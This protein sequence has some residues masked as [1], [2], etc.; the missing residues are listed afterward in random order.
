MPAVGCCC[1]P[2]QCTVCMC[3]SRSNGKMITGPSQEQER[4]RAVAGMEHSA[5][6]QNEVC[7][8]ATGCNQLAVCSTQPQQQQ[9]DELQQARCAGAWRLSH[10]MAEGAG[11]TSGVAGGVAEDVG[12]DRVP[13]LASRSPTCQAFAAAPKAAVA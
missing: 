9:E 6:Q 4:V 7:P 3:S 13:Y 1:L 5:A 11:G 12:D 2:T 10:P 8:R